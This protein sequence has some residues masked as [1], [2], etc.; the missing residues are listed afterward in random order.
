M[1]QRRGL[2]KVG[3]AESYGFSTDAANFRQEIICA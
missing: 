3:G 2:K 1:E